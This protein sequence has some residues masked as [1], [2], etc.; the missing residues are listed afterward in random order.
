MGYAIGC[1]RSSVHRTAAL[2]LN[3]AEAIRMIWQGFGWRGV[4]MRGWIRAT[5]VS[6]VPVL[7]VAAGCATMGGG[8]GKDTSPEVMRVAV[9]ER[10]NARWAALIK[11]DLD[12]AYTYLSPASREVVS[13]ATFKARTRS[14]SFRAAQINSVA[15]EP[16]LCKVNLMLTY[17]H[18]VM[19]SVTTPLT[20]A[21]VVDQGQIWYVW[22]Q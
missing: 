18:R 11:G 19:K 10:V 8:L 13:L 5:C 21:W 15:C 17:D 7:L 14:A 1:G 3:V 20:E 9:T 6:G 4:T 22:Q 2:G 12:L 16:E